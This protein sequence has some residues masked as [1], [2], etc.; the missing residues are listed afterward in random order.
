MAD[1]SRGGHASSVTLVR[2]PRGYVGRDHETIG[3]DILAVLKILKLPEQVL[4]EEEARKL[5]AIKPGSWYPISW[6]LRLMNRL[7]EQLGHY[8]LVRLGR[9][10]FKESHEEQALR[11]LKSARDVLYGLDGMYHHANRGVDIGGWKVARFEAGYAELEKNTPHHCVMEQGIL[12]AACA[13][14]GCPVMIVQKQC[15]RE[16]ADYCL[17]ALSSSL[18]NEKWCGSVPMDP[19]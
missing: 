2:K 14:V 13:A 8:A 10:I 9:T 5:A 17:Y 16:G 18:T 7:D 4:G 12:L 1:A 6:L 11:V 19:P 15:F 3:S